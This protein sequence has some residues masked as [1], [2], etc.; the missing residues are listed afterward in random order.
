[1]IVY[2]YF[3]LTEEIVNVHRNGKYVVC[4]CVCVQVFCSKEAQEENIKAR[5]RGQK[6]HVYTCSMYIV[7]M[8]LQCQGRSEVDL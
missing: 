5:G 8:N 4:V 6:V 2:S 7:L 1:M 3:A